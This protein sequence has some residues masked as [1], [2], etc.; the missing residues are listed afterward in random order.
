MLHYICRIKENCSNAH[1][2]NNRR[3][4]SVKQHLNPFSLPSA[5]A[6]DLSVSRNRDVK[7]GLHELL[8]NESNCQLNQF[9]FLLLFCIWHLG[10][11][12]SS[13]DGIH[14]KLRQAFQLLNTH[15]TRSDYYLDLTA[16]W[17]TASTSSSGSEAEA[18]DTQQQTSTLFT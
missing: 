10:L 14:F 11:L 18:P 2:S 12:Q 6:T 7:Q 1:F 3:T 5:F 8:K 13:A 17:M 9:H 4:N 15:R 16:I